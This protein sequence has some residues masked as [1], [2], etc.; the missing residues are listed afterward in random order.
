MF[1]RL[2]N[3]RTFGMTSLVLGMLA[4]FGGLAHALG[5]WAVPVVDSETRWYAAT[6]AELL[7]GIM[8]LSAA[9]SLRSIRPG[10]WRG[11]LGAHVGALVCLAVGVGLFAGSVRESAPLTGFVGML[12]VLIAL[13]AAGLWHLRPRNPL[14]RAQHEIAARLY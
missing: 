6:V 12:F 9:F 11:A 4:L 3:V 2:N 14:K 7:T 13:N 8:L 5:W 1:T 10:A